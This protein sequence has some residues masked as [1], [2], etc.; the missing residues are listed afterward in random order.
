M[1]ERINS[2]W[3]LDSL[4]TSSVSSSRSSVTIWEVFATES[5]GRPVVRAGRITLPGASAQ[6]RLLVNGTQTTVLTRLRFSASPWTTTTGLRKPGPEPVGSGRLAQYTCPWAITIRHF[7]GYV[8]PRRKWQVRA[9]CPQPHRLDS[10]LQSRLQ[11][12]DARR[13]RS[14]LRH[15]PGYG[16]SSAGGITAPH[17]GKFGPG[18]RSL[19]SYPKYNWAGYPVQTN[20]LGVVS[21]CGKGKD[22]A[23]P[24][25]LPVEQP[26]KFEFIVNLKAA[27]QIG[28]TIP[29]NVL[30]RADRVIVNWMR[31][32]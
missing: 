26:I 23:K 2:S 15:K 12:R 31:L 7:Q 17:H 30:M 5:L 29:P 6:S 21:P 20:H 3:R 25:D 28:L 27:K 4:P 8:S 14:R 1:P 19:F 24:G 10:S 11:D 13:I 9:E 22:R 32:N 18:S 16:I